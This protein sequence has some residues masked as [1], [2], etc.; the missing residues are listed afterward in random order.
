MQKINH[1]GGGEISNK[2]SLKADAHQKKRGKKLSFDTARIAIVTPVACFT[3]WKMLQIE[4]RDQTSKLSATIL[5]R[6]VGFVN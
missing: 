3:H 2:K 1:N 4:V 6:N 5:K